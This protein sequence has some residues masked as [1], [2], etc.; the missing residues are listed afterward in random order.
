MALN[1][2]AYRLARSIQDF[3]PQNIRFIFFS[4][5][6]GAFSKIDYMLGNKTNLNKLK[7]MEITS[8]IFSDH[9]DMRLQI[10]Y[11]NSTEKKIDM[12]SLNNMLLN[13]QCITEEVKE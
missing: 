5:Q 7:K 13:N 11:K 1:N 6:Q 8:S 12:W 9:N 3:L 4:H 10:S 2:R